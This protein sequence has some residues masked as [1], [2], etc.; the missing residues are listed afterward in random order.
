MGQPETE[1]VNGV[2]RVSR[3]SRLVSW[4]KFRCR[5]VINNGES[6]DNLKRGA[7]LVFTNPFGMQERYSIV[8]IIREWWRKENDCY[9][10]LEVRKLSLEENLISCNT[11]GL[12]GTS[13]CNTR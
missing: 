4:R 11:G 1:N 7:E 10:F 12:I 13:T 5:F 2:S 3:V 8:G 9:Y 6:L